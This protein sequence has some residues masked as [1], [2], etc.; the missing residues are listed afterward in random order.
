MKPEWSRVILYLW[1][2]FGVFGFVLELIGLHNDDDNLPPLTTIVVQTIRQH[3]WVG[4]LV[5]GF[6]GWLGVHFG[7]RL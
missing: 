4:L 1:L 3:W 7:R 5:F 6:I 2:A